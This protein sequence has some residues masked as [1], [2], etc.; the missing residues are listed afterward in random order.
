MAIIGIT[1]ISVLMVAVVPNV[2]TIFQSMIRPC[3]GT[4]R[5]SSPSSDFL[6]GYWWI[7]I[8]PARHR[9]FYWFRRWKKTPTGKLKLAPS[10]SRSPSSAS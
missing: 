10:S 7:L 8:L 9:A 2:V 6:S 4:P 3:P 1:L 5:S